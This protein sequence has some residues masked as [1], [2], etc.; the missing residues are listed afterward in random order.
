VIKVNIKPIQRLKA[1]S[2]TARQRA[3][4]CVA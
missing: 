1:H 3:L 4:T 2:H